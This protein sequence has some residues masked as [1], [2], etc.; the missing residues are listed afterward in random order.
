MSTIYIPNHADLKQRDTMCVNQIE[1]TCAEIEKTIDLTIQ[2]TFNS[3]E[4][5]IEQLEELAKAKLAANNVSFKNNIYNGLKLLLVFLLC[6]QFPVAV[7]LEG[8]FASWKITN[9]S[10]FYSPYYSSLLKWTSMS[11]EGGSDW[12]LYYPLLVIDFLCHL[13]L[14]YLYGLNRLLQYLLPA[15]SALFSSCL[16]ALP[17]LLVARFSIRFKKQLGFV[18]LAEVRRIVGRLEGLHRKRR[19]QLYSAY[20]NQMLH[21]VD[22]SH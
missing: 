22:I 9:N 19:E 4:R 15:S 21:D 10:S 16:F 17:I 11:G 1:E 2:S 6:I 7:S 12:Y 14:L 20:L 5:D 18:E 13:F 8:F 3:M